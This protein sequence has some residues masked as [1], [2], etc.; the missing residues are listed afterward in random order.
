MNY[1]KIAQKLEVY[2]LYSLADRFEKYAEQGLYVPKSD[3]GEN[4][5]VMFRQFF[6]QSFEYVQENRKFICP[7]CKLLDLD[8][9]FCENCATQMIKNPEFGKKSQKINFVK[10]NSLI[11]NSPLAKNILMVNEETSGNAAGSF[12]PQT[13]ILSIKSRFNNPSEIQLMLTTLFHENIHAF[14]P[15]RAKFFTTYNNRNNFVKS[16]QDMLDKKQISG[17]EATKRINEYFAKNPL[18][19]M[20]NNRGRTGYFTNEE[21]MAQTQNIYS[22]FNKNNLV[23]LYSKHYK[24]KPLLFINDLRKFIA[25]LQKNTFVGNTLENHSEIIKY[26]TDWKN[27]YLQT[28]LSAELSEQLSDLK[29]Y[30][31]IKKS[32]LSSIPSTKFVELLDETLGSDIFTKLIDI[33]DPKFFKNFI[34]YLGNQTLGAEQ[35]LN[36]QKSSLNSALKNMRPT[37][38]NISAL[39]SK[40]PA[41]N[42]QTTPQIV[43]QTSIILPKIIETFE[44]LNTV[45][46]KISNTPAGKVLRVGLVAKDIAIILSS[47][48]KIKQD[49][50]A[51]NQLQY[52]EIYDLGLSIVSLLT[53]LD[54]AA[55]VQKI[56]PPA[57]I[58]LNNPEV[59]KWMLIINVS[60]NVLMGLVQLA[61]SAGNY[62]GTTDPA[63][64]QTSGILNNP[65]TLQA[66]VMTSAQLRDQYGEIYN[67]LID[68]EKGMRSAEAFSK[69]VLRNDPYIVYKRQLFTKFRLNRNI[70]LANQK[71][72]KTET[73]PTINSAYAISSYKKARDRANLRFVG[74]GSGGAGLPSV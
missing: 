63:L 30:E 5:Q 14:S 3:T 57:A 29:K 28:G 66:L 27:Y 60:A 39:T 7:N 40:S 37:A 56:F 45:I 18:L 59:K 38:K 53:D 48:I 62:A 21:V 71:K 74:T 24:K 11:K 19:Q 44:K 32:Y 72:S 9:G 46:Q 17:A 69:H 61:D 23:R 49:L 43:K 25:G 58:L 2:G 42:K 22:A 20:S 36:I 51:Q 70:L 26:K 4:L 1:L 67:A 35:I 6:L 73:Y 12:D 41:I 33:K 47:A 55:I 54:T 31:S 64:G 65:G 52:K 16:I 10:L 8:G 15:I 13:K 50:D 68:T 34:K